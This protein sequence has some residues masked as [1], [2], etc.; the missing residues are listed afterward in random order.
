MLHAGICFQPSFQPSFPRAETREQIPLYSRIQHISSK[1]GVILFI[2]INASPFPE[3]FVPVP[4]CTCTHTLDKSDENLLVGY[5]KYS[6]ATAIHC[7]NGMG[8]PKFLVPRFIPV[9]TLPP[10]AIG[11]E[12]SQNQE[13]PGAFGSG[14]RLCGEFKVVVLQ[15]RGATEKGII[16]C[17][18]SLVNYCGALL[19]QHPPSLAEA[20]ATRCTPWYP[21][22]ASE[23]HSQSCRCARKTHRCHSQGETWICIWSSQDA[24]GESRT[25]QERAKGDSQRAKPCRHLRGCVFL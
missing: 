6:S 1:R 9:C 16:P 24:P 11:Y 2:S 13:L 7:R 23:T 10:S 5:K 21:R 22:T 12:N 8:Q 20:F 25:K 17:I 4:K 19:Y 15:R 3:G 18:C 14:L